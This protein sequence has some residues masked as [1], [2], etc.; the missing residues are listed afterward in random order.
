MESVVRASS[1]CMTCV[2]PQSKWMCSCAQPVFL[3][4]EC[5]ALACGCGRD[6][7]CLRLVS[8]QDVRRHI[9]CRVFTSHASQRRRLVR[10]VVFGH[11]DTYLTWCMWCSARIAPVRL[12]GT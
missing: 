5:A 8:V 9:C 11:I 2:R 7:G 1:L 3:V 12:S 4:R 6:T 10:P